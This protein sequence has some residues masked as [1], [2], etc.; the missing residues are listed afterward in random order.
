ME[1][2]KLIETIESM[3]VVELNELV[4]SLEDKFGSVAIPVA[5][6]AASNEPAA[7]AKSEFDLVLT[8]FGEKKIAV[9]KVVRA[10]TGL[11]LKEAKELVESAPKVI[12][13]AVPAKEA[14]D[15]KNQLMEAGASVE[16]K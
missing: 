14:E 16:L 3:K 1:I 2:K 5:G 10:I 8:G 12:K 15:F 9:I 11:G 4:K 6:A 13:P 7:E